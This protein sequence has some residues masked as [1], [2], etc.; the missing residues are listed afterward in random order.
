MK[1]SAVVTS[2]IRELREL[3]SMTI[4]LSD[5][6]VKSY[7]ESRQTTKSIAWTLT[8]RVLSCG[9]PLDSGRRATACRSVKPNT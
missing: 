2:S 8:V 6:D 1:T 4:P 3:A 7:R 9:A 5:R